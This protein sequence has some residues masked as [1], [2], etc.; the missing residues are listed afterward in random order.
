[1]Y[2]RLAMLTTCMADHEQEAEGHAKEAEDSDE[3]RVLLSQIYS[4]RAFAHLMI[5]NYRSCKEDCDKALKLTP[6]NVK[7]W[8]RKAKV[9]Y[10]AET[11]GYAVAGAAKHTLPPCL[12]ALVDT[13]WETRHA[14]RCGNM[15]M[16]LRRATRVWRS[17]QKIRR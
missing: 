7:A 13:L 3:L 6:N 16:P 8:Y 1:M 12:C 11:L 10:A 17:T 4:N 2:R 15:G 14:R 5:K 9:C